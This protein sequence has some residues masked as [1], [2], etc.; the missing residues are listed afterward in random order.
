MENL[1]GADG[2]CERCGELGTYDYNPYDEEINDELNI[3][4]LCEKCYQNLCDDI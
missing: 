3:V 2:I 1:L 4:C